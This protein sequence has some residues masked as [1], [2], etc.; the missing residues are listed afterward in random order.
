MP[1]L[2]RKVTG[3]IPQPVRFGARKILFRGNALQCPLCESSVRTYLPHGG[4]FEVLE[5]RVVF[6]L[7]SLHVL[8]FGGLVGG[9][10]LLGLDS[11][12]GV[13]RGL[14]VCL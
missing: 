10:G 13:E 4:G 9:G 11:R 14:H 8:V 12:S 6:D 1:S 5:V 2:R 3:L 7:E